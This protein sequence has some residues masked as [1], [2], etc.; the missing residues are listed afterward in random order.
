RPHRL[1]AEVLMATATTAPS[2][3]P[4]VAWAAASVAVIPAAEWEFVYGSMQSLK[5]H[6]QEYPGC[7]RF[8]AFAEPLEALAAR[9]LL[10]VPLERLHGAVDELPLSGGNDGHGC[11]RPGDVRKCGGRSRRGRHQNFCPQTMWP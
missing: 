10:N 6:V 2:A 8:E 3:L 1:G 9:V 7:Q 5:G 4:Y 11:G